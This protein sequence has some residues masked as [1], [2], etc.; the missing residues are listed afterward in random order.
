MSSDSAEAGPQSPAR[1]TPGDAPQTQKDDTTQKTN[2]PEI[3][4]SDGDSPPRRKS[5][6]GEREIATALQ[7]TGDALPY[8]DEEAP[9]L[10][11]EAPPEDDGWTCE[12]DNNVQNWYFYNRFTGAS[13][14]ENPRVPE[15]TASQHGSYDRFANNLKLSTLPSHPNP[16]SS[17]IRQHPSCRPHNQL[18]CSWY[19]VSA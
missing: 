7:T 18:W 8:D 13:Q 15:A 17:Q 1:I 14:W 6:T 5:S 16:C 3:R 19:F 12:W 4:S 2:D 11:D 10:P 9:P